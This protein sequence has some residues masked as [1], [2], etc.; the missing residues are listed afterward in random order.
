MFIDNNPLSKIVMILITILF[1]FVFITEWR[2]W[3]DTIPIVGKIRLKR[4]RKNK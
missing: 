2:T 3:I 4:I 1:I